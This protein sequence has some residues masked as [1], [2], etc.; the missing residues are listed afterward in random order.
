MS[1]LIMKCLKFNNNFLSIDE[2]FHLISFHDNV[3]L[4]AAM[5][6]MYS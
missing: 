6:E 2:N 1:V 3:G 5:I 4:F